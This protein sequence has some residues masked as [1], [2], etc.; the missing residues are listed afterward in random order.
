[1]PQRIAT[2]RSPPWTDP[3]YPHAKANN[4]SESALIQKILDENP[5]VSPSDIWV[6]HEADD[7][8][9]S[10]RFPRAPTPTDQ[11]ASESAVPFLEALS[12]SGER[13]MLGF[14][15]LDN[16]PSSGDHETLL[17]STMRGLLAGLDGEL[18]DVQAAKFGTDLAH[19]AQIAVGD[20]TLV[21]VQ[22]RLVGDRIYQLLVIGY[23]S[24]EATESNIVRFFEGFR[25]LAVGGNPPTPGTSSTNN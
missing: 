15:T 2:N 21:T 4:L 3:R 6:D 10:A 13:F 22:L 12:V 14:T 1:M 19:I 20:D 23:R 8:R 7:G 11:R 9:F 16:T 24:P 5:D 25:P 17:Q 18:L